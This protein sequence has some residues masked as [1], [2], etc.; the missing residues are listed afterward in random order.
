MSWF[1]ECSQAVSL[2]M[3]TDTR[4]GEVIIDG[5]VSFSV[6]KQTD[7]IQGLGDAISFTCVLHQLV[8]RKVGY[9]LYRVCH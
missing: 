9:Q 2:F 7:V 6:Q 8:P 1:E 4:I 5:C 3:V